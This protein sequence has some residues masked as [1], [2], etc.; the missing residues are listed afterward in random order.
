[1]LALQDQFVFM[2]SKLYV[3]IIQFIPRGFKRGPVRPLSIHKTIP[4]HSPT[5]NATSIHVARSYIQCNDITRYNPPT[6]LSGLFLY[7]I[8]LQASVD[9]L[10]IQS[11]Y[12]PQWIISLYNL[13]T[14][15]SGLFLY[16]ILLQTSVNCF[17]LAAAFFW[18]RASVFTTEYSMNAPNTN[19]RHVAIQTSIAF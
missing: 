12:K 9:Y 1:M 2:I 16:T 18:R 19:T 8:L 3:N 17:F 4:A 13:P 7:T 5:P 6:N 15:L 10:F 11:S 14:N